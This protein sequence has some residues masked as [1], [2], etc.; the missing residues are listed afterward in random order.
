MD[1]VMSRGGGAGGGGS[2]ILDQVLIFFYD[3]I[4]ECL[5]SGFLI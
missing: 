3:N 4:M 1:Q 5:Q 2:R